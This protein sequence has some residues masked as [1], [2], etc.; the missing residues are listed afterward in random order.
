MRGFDHAT[1]LSPSFHG[2]RKER[3]AQWPAFC[4][5]KNDQ[6]FQ[7]EL[8]EKLGGGVRHASS[9]P[10]PI[11]NQNLWFSLPYFKSEALEL[12]VW[13]ERVTICYGRYT[14]VGV[15]NK[16]EMVLSPNDKEVA[17]S[18]KKEGKFKTR[19]YKP[20]PISDQ[21]G[22]NWNP[23]S[24]QNGYKK[25]TL[26]RG[27]YLYSLYKGLPPP[28]PTRAKNALQ[29]MSLAGYTSETNMHRR[30]VIQARLICTGA[31]SHQ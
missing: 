28:P 3:L 14:V 1:T 11:S 30:L 6:E 29:I 5:L 16:R 7:G 24:D 8:P 25:H 2:L 17:S 15:N 23:I 19:V 12:R 20:Y 4:V 10:Y 21:N 27:T 26:W 18:S 13:Q 9:N 22:R 31:E